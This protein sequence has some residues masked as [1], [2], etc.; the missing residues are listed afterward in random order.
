MSTNDTLA[1]EG[2]ILARTAD[3]LD[4]LNQL[5]EAVRDDIIDADMKEFRASA[6]REMQV[7]GHRFADADNRLDEVEQATRAERDGKSQKIAAVLVAELA[8]IEAAL[9]AETEASKKLAPPKGG[10]PS[11]AMLARIA[12]GFERQELRATM[13]RLPMASLLALY[14]R[15]PDNENPGLVSFIEEE[16]ASG[17]PTLSLAPGRDSATDAKAVDELSRL[18]RER[19][20]QRVPLFVREVR[21]KLE[22]LLPAVRRVHLKELTKATPALNRFNK[23]QRAAAKES[24]AI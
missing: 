14:Q 19:H 15:T 9:E 1:G 22:A 20:Q 5:Q 7:K 24:T 16:L 10:T 17:F 21:A 2:A 4:N 23:K 11:E 8:T 12:T 13:V 3:L 6:D 18:V